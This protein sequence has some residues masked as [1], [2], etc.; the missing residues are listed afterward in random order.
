MPNRHQAIIWT[1]A[2]QIYWHIYVA[3]GEDKLK[4][5]F[6]ALTTQ[7]QDIFVKVP[8]F[9]FFNDFPRYCIDDGAIYLM[10]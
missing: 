7:G 1:N 6:P 10:A 2:D 8:L 4:K 9:L 5:C 3:P